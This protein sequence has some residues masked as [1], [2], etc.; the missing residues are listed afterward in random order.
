MFISTDDFRIKASNFDLTNEWNNEYPVFW[1]IV[2]LAV[3]I[4]EFKA[5]GAKSDRVPRGAM[6]HA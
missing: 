2:C 4:H 1:A 3:A 5:Y 6:A